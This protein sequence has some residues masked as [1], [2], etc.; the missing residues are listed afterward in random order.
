M[1]GEDKKHEGLQLEILA[2]WPGLLVLY[3]LQ[4]NI[5]YIFPL[6][7]RWNWSVINWKSEYQMY[8]NCQ[9]A[10]SQK[11]YFLK[12]HRTLSTLALCT[13]TNWCWRKSLIF[14]LRFI[15]NS[16]YIKVGFAKKRVLSFWR[17]K[18]WGTLKTRLAGR[19]TSQ[20]QISQILWTADIFNCFQIL[21]SIFQILSTAN[22]WET[23][24]AKELLAS[25]KM[26]T[27][28]VCADESQQ[29]IRHSYIFRYCVYQTIHS[30]EGLGWTKTVRKMTI[31]PQH[32]LVLSLP[33]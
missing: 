27:D 1:K 2:Q 25:W 26:V 32:M 10:R 30:D 33:N 31:D 16:C 4:S 5:F 20:I 23:L 6:H 12:R 28:S 11:F 19:A 7:V 18:V 8:G 13:L 22:E 15:W 17:F 9:S 24:P 29:W 3:F 21:S 14:D